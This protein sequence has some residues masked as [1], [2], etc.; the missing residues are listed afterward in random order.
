MSQNNE[1]YLIGFLSQVG[2]TLLH[3]IWLRC[4]AVANVNTLKDPRAATFRP[5]AMVRSSVV[6]LFSQWSKHS[7]NGYPFPANI[8]ISKYVLV[9]PWPWMYSKETEGTWRKQNKA[10]KPE[11][12]KRNLMV[13]KG[14]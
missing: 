9:P 6:R 7:W 4:K 8:E 3:I 10:E 5:M 1:H 13:P 14:T 11:E 12:T 2:L